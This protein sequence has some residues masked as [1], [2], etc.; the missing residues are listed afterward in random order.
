MVCAIA[1]KK[2]KVTLEII[3]GNAESVTGSCTK[4]NFQDRLILFECGM[5]Q[6]GHTT[7]ENYRLNSNLLSKIKATSVD[8]IIIGHCHC[9]HIA[10][11]PALYAKNCSADII[12]PKGSTS[13][14]KEMWLDCC[15]INK[16][17]CEKL[18]LKSDSSYAP[19]YTEDNVYTALGHIK[20][21]DVGVITPFDEQ[22]SIR[23]VPAGHILCSCQAEVFINGG[24]HTRKIVFTSD[25]GNT[26]T[27]KERVFVEPFQPIQKANIVIGE[28]TY[29][30]R[31][32][33]STKN[34]IEKDIEK[35][36]AVIQQ[37]CI[38]S[39]NR[40]LIPTFSLDRCPFIL[41]ELYKAFGHDE[42]FKVPIIVDSPLTNRLLNCYSSILTGEAKEKF[43]QMMAWKNIR[44]IIT[45]ED[46]K[47]AI[48]DSG[49]KVILA[50]SGMLTAGRSIKWTQSVLP[51]ENDCIL[52]VGYAGEDTLAYKIKNGNTQKTINICGKPIRNRAQ[53]VTLNGF[54]S[55]M[56][57]N[58]LINYYKGF[59]CEKIYLVH[60]NAKDRLELK[61][62][63]EAAV[64]DCLKTTRIVAVNKGTKISI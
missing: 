19:L 9:D 21:L 8:T 50:S 7:L 4:I 36:K 61:A 29:A 13:I 57:R 26:L 18:S 3:G 11:I 38:D 52:F 27:E 34:D 20:E 30:K 28:S 33:S 51:R 44:R 64:S 31:G 55:H 10:L 6:D 41:W 14:I 49:A 12:V 23:Y 53:I 43:N 5:I 25:L 42:S 40:V 47:A 39:K 37:Y 32:R 2:D 16:R 60:S 63:L 35:M 1:K 15:Y 24:S 17:D 48:T 54:S 46:S 56:Q 45:P 59:N 22:L 62:D 58:E